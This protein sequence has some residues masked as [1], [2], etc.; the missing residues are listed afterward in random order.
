M[1]LCVCVCAVA[2]ILMQMLAQLSKST[3]ADI[4]IILFGG[5]PSTRIKVE[6]GERG[7]M[8]NQIAVKCLHK[9]SYL[10]YEGLNFKGQTAQAAIFNFH[11]QLSFFQTKTSVQSY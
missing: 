8:F 2:N 5:F 9:C 7:L 4:S 6:W 1:P 11:S 3:T 10:S